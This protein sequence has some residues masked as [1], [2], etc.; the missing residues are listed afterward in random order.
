[1]AIEPNNG[2]IVTFGK[3]YCSV[4]ADSVTRLLENQGDRINEL[5]REDLPPD[6]YRKRVLELVYDEDERKIVDAAMRALPA[7]TIPIITATWQHAQASGKRFRVDDLPLADDEVKSYRD[8]Q[9]VRISVDYDQ[10]GVTVRFGHDPDY[11]AEWY[12]P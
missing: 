5:L 10:D 4:A 6:E 1:M 7:T 3:P 8:V 2:D 11:H 12:K 9:R